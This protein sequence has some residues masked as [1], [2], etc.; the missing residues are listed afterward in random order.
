MKI[1]TGNLPKKK[2]KLQSIG[3]WG[4]PGSQVLTDRTSHLDQMISVPS[5]AINAKMVEAHKGWKL[6][7]F[8]ADLSWVSKCHWFN[9][10]IYISTYFNRFFPTY[11]KVFLRH[12]KISQ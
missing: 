1:D 8:F 9:K 12:F 5:F 11:F 2:Q 4:K 10:Y 7:Q 6:D 3:L